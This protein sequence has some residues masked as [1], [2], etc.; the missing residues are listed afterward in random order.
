MSVNLRL[1][2]VKRRIETD[3]PSTDLLWSFMV[4]ALSSYRY[5]TVLRPFPPMYIKPL[6][7]GTVRAVDRHSAGIE[8]ENKDYISLK[9]DVAHCQNF[10]SLDQNLTVN[11]RL[12]ELVLWTISGKQFSLEMCDSRKF[13]EIRSLTGDTAQVVPPNYIFEVSYCQAAEEKFNILRG[14]RPIIYAYHGSR[15]ENFHSILHY[16]LQGHLN[17]N[18]VFG[19]GTYL[20]S[21]LSVSIQYSPMGLGWDKSVLGDWMSCVAVCELIDDPSVKCKLQE[22]QQS[23]TDA[24]TRSPNPRSRIPNSIGGEI[25][26]KYY[27][28]RNNDVMRVKFLLIYVRK[29][30]L[31]RRTLQWLQKYKFVILLAVYIIFLIVLGLFRSTT[32][33]SYLKRVFEM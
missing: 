5:D 8:T 23:T 15:L 21:E 19:E 30:N 4:A 26:E 14:N 24:S 17:K 32:V 9:K 1:S 33:R 27:V 29:S 11:S 31:Q 10:R 6:T 22:S 12:L 13:S 7:D 3:L 20:S 25:P 16:G 18:A 2:V 28:V